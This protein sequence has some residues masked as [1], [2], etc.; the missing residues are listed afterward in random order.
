MRVAVAGGTGLTGRHVVAEL[1]RAGHDP[2]VLSRAAGVDLTDG[3]G[4]DAALAAADA[5]VDVTNIAT[6]KRSTAVDFF[7][8]VGRTLLSGAER[9]KVRRIVSLS[10]IGID[11]VDSGYY[12]G[13]RVQEDV[14]RNGSVPWTI[15]RAAQFHEFTDQVL[16][17]VPGPVAVVPKMLSQPIAVREVAAALVARLDDSGSGMAAEIAGPK[18]EFQPD[19]ARR[20][21]RARGSRR[22]VLPVRMPG[23]AGK[24]MV[25]G[26]LLPKHEFVQGVQTFDEWLAERTRV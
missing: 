19:L 15:L 23:K 21:L 12:E 5:I 24:A 17:F 18:P 7:G 26:A 1:E 3:S 2:V 14:L 9:A 20:L 13:K 10:I 16:G 11:D 4:L 8:T 25:G 22:L 6:Q